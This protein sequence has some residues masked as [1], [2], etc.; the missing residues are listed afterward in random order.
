MLRVTL[1]AGEKIYFCHL[2]I[3]LSR[4]DPLFLH[5]NAAGSLRAEMVD[6]EA[7]PL[8]LQNLPATSSRDQWLERLTARYAKELNEVPVAGILGVAAF[9]G[10]TVVLNGP[11]RNIQLQSTAAGNASPQPARDRAVIDLAA[12]PLR[13]GILLPVQL[14]DGRTVNFTLHSRDPFSFIQPGLAKRLGHPAGDLRSARAGALNFAA[15]TPFRPL[16]SPAGHVGGI[17][18]AVIEQMVVTLQLA[19][20]RAI[21]ELPEPRPYPEDEAEYYRA[22]SANGAEKVDALRTFANENTKS[23]W[24]HEASSELLRILSEMPSPPRDA[25]RDGAFAAIDSARDNQRGTIALSVLEQ[26][27]ETLDDDDLKIEVI[28]KAL[29]QARADEDGNATHK[30]RL[31][32]GKIARQRQDNNGARRHLLSAAFGMPGNGHAHLELGKL[33]EQMGELKRALGRYF[34]AMLDMK[35]TGEDGLTEFTRLHEKVGDGEP[36]IPLLE[37]MSE[38]RVPALHPIPREPEEIKPTGRIIL[39]ELFTG[40]H[41]PPCAAADVAIDALAEYY[42]DQEVAVVQWH[43]PAAGPEPMISPVAKERAAKWGVRGTPTALIAGRKKIVGGGKAD[44]APSMLTKYQEVLRPLLSTEPVAKIEAS[45]KLVKDSIQLRA[46]VTEGASENLRLHAILV[47]TLLLYPGRNGILFHHRVARARMTP[48]QGAPTDTP[49]KTDTS[50]AVVAMKLDAAVAA[51]ETREIFRVRP[52]QP[53][54]DHLEVV[55]FLEDISSREVPQALT[56][57]VEVEK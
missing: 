17:G 32:L 54:P 20:G 56:I 24:C 55:L 3:D 5:A 46:R 1:R 44:Q 10:Y 50:L 6:V 21:L 33:Y 30:L 23:R 28:E 25:F 9:K 51:L 27:P 12:D 16:T 41:C 37:E 36:L 18:G 8:R 29:P 19:Q 7:G 48:T 49:L 52:T 38:G 22:L 34:L 40:A 45:A 35:N 13:K 31:E 47:E 4:T 39:V 2:L 11:D 43:L 14:D 57:R 53:N 15:L 26:W 42:T